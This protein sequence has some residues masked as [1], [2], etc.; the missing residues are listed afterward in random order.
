MKHKI[1]DSVKHPIWISLKWVVQDIFI[2]KSRHRA[3]LVSDTGANC[4]AFI[5]DLEY[6][7]G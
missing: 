2:Y 7:V 3:K 1:G 6:W 5:D 4:S